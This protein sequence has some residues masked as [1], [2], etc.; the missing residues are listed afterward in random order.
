MEG[1]V[2]SRLTRSTTAEAIEPDLAALWRDVARQGQV[3]RAVMSNLVVFRARREEHASQS[4]AALLEEVAARHPC[5]LIVLDHQPHLSHTRAPFILTIGIISFG[6]EAARYAIEQIDVKSTCAEDCLPSIVRQLVRGDVPTS[7]WWMDDVSELAPLDGIVRIGRQFVYDSRRWRD[8]RRGI[9]A[10]AGLLGSRSSL[11]LADLNWRRLAPL[12]QALLHGCTS[13]SVEAIGR[14]PVRIIHRPGDSALAWLTAGWL[15][16]RLE[17]PRDTVLHVEEAARDSDV[18]IIEAAGTAATL[19][20]DRVTVRSGGI[21]PLS[22]A[23]PRQ[24]AADI[25]AEELRD[26]SHDVCLH[27]AVRAAASLLQ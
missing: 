16:S 5:R 6:T 24:D 7:V 27:D 20:S 14:G 13:A 8:V 12:R 23:V 19:D 1:A 18:L 26:L 2:I 4:D 21:A 22:V 11:D 3:A 9:S 10:A 25:V 15:A 17:W